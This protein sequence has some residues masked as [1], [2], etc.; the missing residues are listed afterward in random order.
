MNL[1]PADKARLTILVVVGIACW[2]VMGII[3][4]GDWIRKKFT[5]WS[6]DIN[7]L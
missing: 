7:I 2:L 6:N 3:Y 4:W 1:S 5:E